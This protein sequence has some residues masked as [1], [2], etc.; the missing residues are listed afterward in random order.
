[1]DALQLIRRLHQHR[2]WVNAK[3]VDAIG[4]LTDD[5]R[6]RTFA[7]GQGSL[8]KSV[9]HLY[10]AEYVW[11]EALFGHETGVVPGDLPGKIPGNQEGEG[12][13][14]GWNDLKQKWSDLDR[15]W[16]SYLS[17]LTPESLD[18]M[19][20]R[21]RTISGQTKRLGT[22]RADVLLHVCTHAHYTTAQ[23][24]NMLRQLGVESLPDP[25]LISLARQEFNG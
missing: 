8:W 2:L 13:I 11:L 5:Q 15:R 14:S 1:M 25:M 21:T 4:T 20:S 3:L 6:R 22:R 7:I 23:V 10:A 24:I 12:G 9:L 19:V 16:N 18:E 17:S